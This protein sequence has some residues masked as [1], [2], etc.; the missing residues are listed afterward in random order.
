MTRISRINLCSI[1]LSIISKSKPRLAR[2]SSLQE[3]LRAFQVQTLGWWNGR[4]VRL[5]GVCRKACGFKSRPEHF[6]FVVGR[7]NA[8]PRDSREAHYKVGQVS[9]LFRSAAATWKVALHY[10][11]A[12]SANL[13][14]RER[15][16]RWPAT[17][18]AVDPASADRV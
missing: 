4:H 16:R 17:T 11:P 15:N 8:L 3:I 12:R 9:N 14:A 2:A 13:R 1:L 18:A 5:R 6:F 10:E 7:W